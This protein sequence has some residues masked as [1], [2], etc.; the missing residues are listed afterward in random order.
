MHYYQ[1]NIGDY[2][3]HTR[4]LTPI[5]DIC[6]R[7]AL[8]YYYLH[9]QPLTLDIKKLSRLLMLSDYHNELV[10]VVNEFFEQTEFGYINT[11]ADK[12]IKQYQGFAEAG[13]RGAAKRWSK[14]GNSPPNSPL[15]PP[16]MLNNNK[17]PLNNKQIKTSATKVACPTGVSLNIWNDYLT[18]RR[19]KKLPITETALSG[20]AR[21]AEKANL[22]LEQTIIIC[23]ERGW[24]GFKADWLKAEAIKEKDNQDWRTNDTAMVKKA[25]ELKVNTKGK[26]RFEL[27]AAIDMKMREL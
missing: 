19:S 24:G 18:L 13:K 2:L 26:T 20:I 27:I 9:E 12:E 4:H 14:D 5:E 1:F 3:S 21:E 7:R 15:N 22:T 23:C 11:R 6:Y 8:D 17:E 25:N 10:S 16:L